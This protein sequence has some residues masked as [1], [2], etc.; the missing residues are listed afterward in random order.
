MRGALPAHAVHAV[1]PDAPPPVQAN[2]AASATAGDII[3]PLPPL[4]P[5]KLLPPVAPEPPGADSH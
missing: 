1:P 5:I 2:A 3:K 4:P